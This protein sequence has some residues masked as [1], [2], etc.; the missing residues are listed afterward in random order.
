MFATLGAIGNMIQSLTSAVTTV[1]ESANDVALIGRVH[2]M[3]ML[4][5]TIDEAGDLKALRADLEAIGLAELTK[6]S[7]TKA[8]R[9][10][11]A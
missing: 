9:A 4:K 7:P 5:E 11:K 2:T 8:A 3:S 6:P 1:C 10:T